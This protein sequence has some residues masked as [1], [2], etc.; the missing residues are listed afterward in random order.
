[1]R[2]LDYTRSQDE[3]IP[4]VG[5]E[6]NYDAIATLKWM[7]EEVYLHFPNVMT[8][9]EEST[10]FLSIVPDVFGGLGFDL[11]GI[12]WMHDSLSYIKEDLSIVSTIMTL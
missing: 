11:S 3:W 7:N 8:I 1:M 10:A 5:G 12:W 6:K 2:Y 4:N 9:A